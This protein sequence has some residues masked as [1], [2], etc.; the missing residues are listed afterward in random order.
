MATTTATRPSFGVTCGNCTKAAGHTVKHATVHDV[1]ECY[2][3]RYAPVDT[4]PDYEGMM[5]DDDAD[6][7]ADRAADAWE[8]SYWGDL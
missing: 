7:L 2:A 4:E 8:R 6:F 1:R 5:A 3:D